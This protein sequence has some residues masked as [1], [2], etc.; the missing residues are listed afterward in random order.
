MNKQQREHATLD[1]RIK[2]FQ[3]VDNYSEM[4]KAIRFLCQD[5][6]INRKRLPTLSLLRWRFD[7]REVNH[8]K[9]ETLSQQLDELFA[10]VAM[11]AKCESMLGSHV[12]SAEVKPPEDLFSMTQVIDELHDEWPDSPS[13]QNLT[14]SDVQEGFEEGM[15]EMPS[16]L[17]DLLDDY[18][19]AKM[20]LNEWKNEDL[21]VPREVEEMISFALAKLQAHMKAYDAVGV[22]ESDEAVI[23]KAAAEDG[24]SLESISEAQKFYLDEI[25]KRYVA[26]STKPFDESRNLVQFVSSINPPSDLPI[27]MIPVE[28]KERLNIWKGRNIGSIAEVNLRNKFSVSA[29]KW[30]KENGATVLVSGVNRAIVVER[31]ADIIANMD[32]PKTAS[33]FS[34]SFKNKAIPI[35]DVVEMLLI[36]GGPEGLTDLELLQDVRGD[37]DYYEDPLN[38]ERVPRREREQSVTEI[39]RSMR[40]KGMIPQTV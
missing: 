26:Y 21:A 24:L 4:R 35:N 22:P 31:L 17:E 20:L 2:I 5:L 1:E 39:F 34:K 25:P 10:K 9:F 32:Y 40:N 6:D 13:V 8:P 37:Y 19:M 38:E 14:L 12:W 11:F 36:L 33:A 29:L 7:P 27:T 15:T 3:H 16:M 30:L 23:S 18:D 28:A